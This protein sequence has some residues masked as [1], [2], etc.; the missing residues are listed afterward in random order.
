VTATDDDPTGIS[1]D[2]ALVTAQRRAIWTLYRYAGVRLVEFV[3]SDEVQ[4]PKLEVADNGS[5]TLTV[6]G[7]GRKMRVIPSPA[8]CRCCRRTGSCAGCRQ[9]RAR[10]NMRR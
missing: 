2:R 6:L 7:K 3:L 8:V 1:S 10:S 9:N 5:W 4:L